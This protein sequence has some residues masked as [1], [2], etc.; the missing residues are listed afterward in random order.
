MGLG[1]LFAV[2]LALT[3]VEQWTMGK[4]STRDEVSR[5]VANLPVA[6]RPILQARFKQ[7]LVQEGRP[8]TRRE[9]GGLTG[10]IEDCDRIDQQVA[11]LDG[12]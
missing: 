9:V 10:G 4:P 6:C 8:L 11:G 7:K 3:G 12:G 1:G 2:V 5:A